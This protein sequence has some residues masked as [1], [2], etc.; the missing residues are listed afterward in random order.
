MFIISKRTWPKKWDDVEMIEIEH[1]CDVRN[2]SVYG[3]ISG[4]ACGITTI[5]YATK[6]DAISDLN[7]LQEYNFG[8]GFGLK[9]IRIRF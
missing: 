9:Q 3:T 6:E 4:D 2:S 7:K 5:F 1:L 8:G